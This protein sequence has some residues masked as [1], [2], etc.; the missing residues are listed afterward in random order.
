MGLLKKFVGFVFLSCLERARCQRY[1]LKG[2]KAGSVGSFIDN[3][4][5]FPDNIKYDGKG[6]FWIGLVAVSCVL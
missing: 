4:P 5:A 2:E 1:W 3:L 6:H